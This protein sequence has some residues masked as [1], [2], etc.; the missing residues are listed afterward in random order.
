MAQ[1]SRG[2]NGSRHGGRPI[3]HMDY[4]HKQGIAVLMGDTA[5]RLGRKVVFD[6]E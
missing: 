2:A 6:K 1:R 4:G 5:C 3:A